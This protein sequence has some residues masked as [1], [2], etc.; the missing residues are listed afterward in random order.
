MVAGMLVPAGAANAAFSYRTL[1][2]RESKT[3]HAGGHEWTLY[4]SASRYGEG[5]EDML[6]ML[7]RT[8]DLNG[9]AR[10]SHTATFS[11]GGTTGVVRIP[12]DLQSAS[13][14]SGSPNQLRPQASS[15][16]TFDATG[17]MD[18]SCGGDTEWRN[19]QLSGR[20]TFDGGKLGE[21]SVNMDGIA[22]RATSDSCIPT[23]GR[24]PCPERG[25]S[26]SASE[27][28]VD[29]MVS[30][31]TG[32]ETATVTAAVSKSFTMGDDAVYGA[33]FQYFNAVVAADQVRIP[34]T[35]GSASFSTPGGSFIP[36]SGSFD[37][38]ALASEPFVMGCDRAA[39]NKESVQ[40]SRSGN[41]RSNIVIESGITP[42]R[43]LHDFGNMDATANKTRVR[44]AAT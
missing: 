10:T 23:F 8:K 15:N 24:L 41:V 9:V 39:L 16:V 43:D 35:L 30:K 38:T 19:G 28:P 37:A 7:T 18:R 34:D 26:V 31:R 21:V 25:N 14:K 20:L 3:I 27:G 6:I 4:F 1:A 12:A 32:A 17:A 42:N 29:L 36:G 33:L 44:T 11:F 2:T 13:V 40:T 22:A 5:G